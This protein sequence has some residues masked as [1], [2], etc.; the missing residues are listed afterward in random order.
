MLSVA[1][2][3]PNILRNNYVRAAL[4]ASITAL[5]L[6]GC[7]KSSQGLAPTD[8]HATVT[9]PH[10][11]SDYNIRCFDRQQGS[12]IM[13]CQAQTEGT[14]RLY[15][16]S[17]EDPA[18]KPVDTVVVQSTKGQF[19]FVPQDVSAPRCTKGYVTLEPTG[20]NVRYQVYAFDICDNSR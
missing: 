7:S 20:T 9:N 12:L 19:A 3:S 17:Y 14:Y 16:G 11:R 13:S 5:A 4:V 1:E 15:E 10:I 2:Q 6:A 18:N 8:P